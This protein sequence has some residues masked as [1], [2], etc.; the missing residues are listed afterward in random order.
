MEDNI[1]PEAVHQ[2]KMELLK[3]E[4]ASERVQN[5]LATLLMRAE[6]AEAE[7]E[8]LR[9]LFAAEQQATHAA[10]TRDADQIE[11]LREGFQ[12]F[13]DKCE[14]TNT[15]A[16]HQLICEANKLLGK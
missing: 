3:A 5:Q 9:E 12:V 11:R 13:L 16:N 8:R 4:W 14:L 6:K 1:T 2:A 15:H 7:V 10:L